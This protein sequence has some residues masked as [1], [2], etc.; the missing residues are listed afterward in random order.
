MR[1]LAALVAF[2]AIT[3]CATVQTPQDA[4]FQ[5]RGA[6]NVA[7]RTAVEYKRLPLCNVPAK[8]PCSDK[9]VVAQLQKADT[10]SDQA[11]GAAESAVRSKNFGADI[12]YNSVTAARAALAA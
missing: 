5:A 12:A 4:V 6:Q 1:K 10:V 3:G 11:L 8:P 7:L 2:L 9:A